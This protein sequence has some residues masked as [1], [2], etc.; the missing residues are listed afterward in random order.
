MTPFYHAEF[1][2]AFLAP[3]LTDESGRKKMMGSVMFFEAES[4]EEVRKVVEADPYFTGD[5]WDREKL[6][7]LPFVPAMHWPSTY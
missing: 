3:E 5:V 7:I 2:G 4:M 1:G 6:I